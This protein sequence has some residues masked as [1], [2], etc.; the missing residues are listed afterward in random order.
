MPAMGDLSLNVSVEGSPDSMESTTDHCAERA[1]AAPPES[2][3]STE[4]FTSAA[5]TGRPFNG[6]MSCQRALGLMRKMSV[7]ASG[8]SGIA[9]ARSG[10]MTPFAWSWYVSSRL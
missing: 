8:V 1:K 5:V 10:A 2:C 3:R 4:Y 7:W 6:W 9:A